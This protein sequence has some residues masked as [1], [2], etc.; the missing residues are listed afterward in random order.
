[1]SPN[2][3]RK[4][5]GSWVVLL[6]GSLQAIEPGDVIINEVYYHPRT[7]VTNHYEA[8]ELLV[9]KDKVDLNG[10]QLSDRDVWNVPTEYQCTL[11]DAGKGFLKSVPSGTLIVIYDGKGDDDI[12]HSDFTLKLYARSS[13]YCNLGGRTN[14]FHLGNYG[15]NL[16]LMHVGKQ[17]DF[18][19]YRPND[20][21]ERGGDPGSLDW[22]KGFDGFIDVGL[23]NENVGFRFIGDKPYLNDFLATWMIYPET[24]LES[25]NLGKPNGGRNTAWIEKLRESSSAKAKTE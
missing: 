2:S 12:D 6:A 11:Q 19:K 1:M 25:D 15:D 7:V 3:L 17:V 5:S 9:V 24:Y 22:E 16:H 4:W 10:L 14:A 23:M 21:P 13:L 18:L 20:R 8:V